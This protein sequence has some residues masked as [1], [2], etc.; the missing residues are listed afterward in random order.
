[1]PEKLRTMLRAAKVKPEPI[2][3]EP[4]NV[5]S[6]PFTAL[7][8]E[9]AAMRNCESGGNAWA[10]QA[11]HAEIRR[12]MAAAPGMR[13]HTLNRAAFALGQIV[14]GGGLDRGRVADALARAARAAG[15]DE[16]EIGPTI[17]SGL[18]DGA[19][20]PRTA[21]ERPQERVQGA[22]S[23]A[24]QSFGR[25]FA[26]RALAE[27]LGSYEAPEYLVDGVL[28]TRRLYTVTAPTGHGKTAAMAYLASCIATGRQFCGREVEKGA[29]L[30][31]AGENADDVKGRFVAI[32]ERDGLDL[33]CTP[34]FFAEHAFSIRADL[35]KIEAFAASI[36]SLRCVI[37]DTFAAYFDGE[38]ENSNA[39]ALDFTRVLRRL[40]DMPG[41]PCVLV[42]A[43]PVKNAG[44]DNLSPKGGSSLVNEVDGNLTIWRKD[45]VAEISWHT[46]WR[47][48]TF[49]PLSIEFETVTSDRLRDVK[50]RQ[51]P[52]VI[53]KPVLTLRAAELSAESE[54]IEDRALAALR[55]NG[56]ITMAGLAAE[57]GSSKSTAHAVKER[58]VA[59]G[60]IKKKGR[61][62]MLTSD[63]DEVL[64]G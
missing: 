45:S 55:A 61:A 21:P 40:V 60:W 58:L 57:I 12:V 64:D 9:L 20:E 2:A 7:A 14:A 38:D 36:P 47:G 27:F 41:G 34:I 33:A 37:V 32:A 51:M 39:Q 25:E 5:V 50:G 28:Q 26:A 59:A 4:T 29:V 35:A 15:L 1:V 46:K 30:F 13:N 31:L 48:P 19:S 23:A 44:R 24:P 49:D 63:G 17:A 42:P 56:R 3:P 10:E 53:A 18:D 52:T 43:H 22:P 8:R 11:M 6:L 62:Y 16:H 54:R